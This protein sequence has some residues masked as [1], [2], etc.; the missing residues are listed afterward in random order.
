[1][2]YTAAASASPTITEESGLRTDF[3]D[4]VSSRSGQVNGGALGDLGA[5]GGGLLL[6]GVLGAV[7]LRAWGGLQPGAG[8]GVDGAFPVLPGHAGHGYLAAAATAAALH[9]PR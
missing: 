2:T 4:I 5:R 8:D 7:R 1:M 6:D 9:D 3:S